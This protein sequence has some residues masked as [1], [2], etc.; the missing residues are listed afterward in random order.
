MTREGYAFG[1]ARTWAAVC[2]CSG[3]WLEISRVWRATFRPAAD[4]RV[5]DAVVEIAE[6]RDDPRTAQLPLP[7]LEKELTAMSAAGVV[8]PETVV[9]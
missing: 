1:Y 8:V 2:R 5:D 4:H 3:P 6:G 7:L 9:P